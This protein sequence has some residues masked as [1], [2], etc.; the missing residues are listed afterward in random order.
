MEPFA[1]IFAHL[2]NTVIR[3]RIYAACATRFAVLALV[4]RIQIVIVATQDMH[5]WE[6]NVPQIVLLTNILI[7]SVIHHAKTVT[8]P[9]PRVIRLE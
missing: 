6:A 9:V 1:Q 2:E 5:R 3:I 7:M 8:L 4:L